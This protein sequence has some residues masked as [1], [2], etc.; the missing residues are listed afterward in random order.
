[1]FGRDGCHIGPGA[2]RGHGGG[3]GGDG[4]DGS[5]DSDAGC[6]VGSGAAVARVHTP[7]VGL[8]LELGD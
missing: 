1:M 6:S 2:G 4:S 8:Y 7:H 3:D 5:D